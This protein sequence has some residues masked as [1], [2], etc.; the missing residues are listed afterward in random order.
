M[1]LIA[2][3]LSSQAALVQAEVPVS[4]VAE[5]SQAIVVADLFG[6]LRQQL[7]NK[8]REVVNKPADAGNSRAEQTSPPVPQNPYPDQ[9][10][11]SP[12]TGKS[13]KSADGIG[14]GQVL[15]PLPF[16]ERDQEIDYSA[17]KWHLLKSFPL[18]ASEGGGVVKKILPKGMKIDGLSLAVHVLSYS[19]AELKKPYT[20][21]SGYDNLP[22]Q[23]GDKI[24]E[25]NYL[26]EGECRVWVKGKTYNSVCFGNDDELTNISHISRSGKGNDTHW[27][28][29]RTPDG[30]EGWLWIK[31]A[32]L[33]SI[34]GI[35][36]HD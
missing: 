24:V 2:I 35:S 14:T 29:V 22:L 31:D 18:Y 7:E 20:L 17:G 26:G 27:A 12:Q 36:K 16:I 25:L 9:I 6:D 23:R 33:K 3:G 32:D 11:A 34:R 8:A 1:L 28:L 4:P 30:M 5:K 19:V 10:V 15:P 13:K 21:Q